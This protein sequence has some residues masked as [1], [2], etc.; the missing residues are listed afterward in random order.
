MISPLDRPAS[1]ADLEAFVPQ[2]A[3]NLGWAGS[4]RDHYDETMIESLE[5][6]LADLG[7]TGKRI[8]FD[9]ARLGLR[10]SDQRQRYRRWVRFA[11][12]GP[13][14]KD[15]VRNRNAAEVDRHQSG[16]D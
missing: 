1:G 2:S 8:A 11:D 14:R 4:A 16:G 15:A 13:Q 3:D 5:K 7:L 12:V 9:D 6:A 10:V